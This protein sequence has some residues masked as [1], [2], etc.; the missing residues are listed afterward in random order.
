[1]SHTTRIP[2]GTSTR[3][4]VGQQ[5]HRMELARSNSWG[6]EAE[7]GGGGRGRG[8][9][10]GAEVGVRAQNLPSRNVAVVFSP[11]IRRG[12]ATSGNRTF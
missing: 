4:C 3:T 7:V 11:A 9:R 8:W 6:W 12:C 10:R 2:T 1:M 5:A